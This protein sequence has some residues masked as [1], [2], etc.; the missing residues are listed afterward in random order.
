[1]DQQTSNDKDYS[2]AS[3]RLVS[4]G[5]VCSALVVDRFW[6]YLVFLLAELSAR[7]LERS[8]VSETT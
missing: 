7:L 8:S 4:A 5:S 6:N 3:S 1:M 2:A